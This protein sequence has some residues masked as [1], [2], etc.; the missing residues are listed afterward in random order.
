MDRKETVQQ[1]DIPSRKGHDAIFDS[2]Y[3]DDIQTYISKWRSQ[4]II[5]VASK[6]LSTTSQHIQ[7]LE[8]LLG[9]RLAAT[10]LGV[11]S[12]S[13][14]ADVIEIAH[15][16]QS[17][18]ADCLI[19]L[20]S[21][22][23]SDASKIAVYLQTSMPLHFSEADMEASID[24]TRGFGALQPATAKLILVPTSLSAGEWN[25]TGSCTNAQGKKQ[26]FGLENHCDGGADLILLDPELAATAP[27]RLWLS[28][29]V[30][31]IDHCVET[32]TNGECTADAERDALDGLRWMLRG[33][34]EYREGKD[35]DRSEMLRGIS[36][37]QRGSRQAIK[38]LIVHRNSFGPSHAI[39]HQLGSAAGVMHGITSCV[40]LPAV[41]AYTETKT[42]KAQKKILEVFN[43]TLAWEEDS[44]SHALVK[45]IK[46]LGLP[47]SLAEVDVKDDAVIEQIAEKTMTDVWGGGK[48]SLN[49]DDILKILNWA[50]GS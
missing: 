22:S 31:C 33:L 50:R 43:Q 41:L 20:G 47:T 14:Y 34:K 9:P 39:G 23:Y 12:H 25:G 24:Q 38:G 4:R 7:D 45:F 32:V 2:A 49:K 42:K 48:A 19:S 17:H 28:S 27:E 6:G 29:G 30:R 40:V 44:A 5:L 21:G 1:Y 3:L 35:R 46:M 37:C 18:N 26:H 36:E 11:G 15:L 8:H 16:L 13:P 10:K